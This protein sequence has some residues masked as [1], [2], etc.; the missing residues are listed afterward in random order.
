MIHDTTAF[1]LVEAH[2]HKMFK[3]S[4]FLSVPENLI[5]C[6]LQNCRRYFSTKRLYV[7]R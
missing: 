5:S 2:A 4:D 3:Q 7:I 6:L 1:N